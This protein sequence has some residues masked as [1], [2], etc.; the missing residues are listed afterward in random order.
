M[1][2][3]HQGPIGSKDSKR[4]REWQRL[5]KYVENEE[6]ERSRGLYHNSPI[7]TV[8]MYDRPR[9]FIWFKVRMRDGWFHNW[10]ATWA[11]WHWFSKNAIS[12]AILPIYL[13]MV[14]TLTPCMAGTIHTPMGNSEKPYAFQLWK[15]TGVPGGNTGME[16]TCKHCLPAQPRDFLSVRLKC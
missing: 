10:C 13:G 4:A 1:L 2:N 15:E 8:R 11:I 9:M 5:M 12:N 6:R 14:V 7:A 3:M 16:K